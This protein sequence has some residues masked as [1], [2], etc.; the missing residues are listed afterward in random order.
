MWEIIFIGICI[1]VGTHII[2]RLMFGETV[3]AK[4][5]RRA[6]YAKGYR[7]GSTNVKMYFTMKKT[8]P[9]TGWINSQSGNYLNSRPKIDAALKEE[10]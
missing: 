9:S 3:T 6:G 5:Y 1:L 10:E 7:D 2:L 4:H 8:L